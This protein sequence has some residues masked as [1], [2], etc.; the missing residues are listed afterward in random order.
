MVYGEMREI[1]KKEKCNEG[2]PSANRLTEQSG[3]EVV[4]Q[5]KTSALVVDEIHL[6]CE[7]MSN[8]VSMSNKSNK[9]NSGP[10]ATSAQ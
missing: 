2:K 8:G 3:G 5:V 10:M 1:I 4:S 9:W 7:A 6:Y